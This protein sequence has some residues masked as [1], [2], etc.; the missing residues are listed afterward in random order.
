M[1]C[2]TY[3]AP[4]TTHVS[5]SELTLNWLFHSINDIHDLLYKELKMF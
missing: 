2:L 4:Q 5:V 3:A 1:L